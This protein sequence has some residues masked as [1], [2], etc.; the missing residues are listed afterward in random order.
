MGGVK[1]MGGSEK[2]DEVIFSYFPLFWQSFLSLF[3]RLGENG[4]ALF[5]PRLITVWLSAALAFGTSGLALQLGANQ[6]YAA[7]AAGSLLLVPTQIEFGTSCYVQ[8]WLSLLTIMTVSGIIMNTKR[9]LYIAGICAGL[10]ASSKYS[11]LFVPLL[12][13]FIVLLHQPHRLKTFLLMTAL[14]CHTHHQQ[15]SKYLQ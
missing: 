9:G 8:V 6:K 14:C 1:K 11:G 5:N 13:T 2:T 4:F 10:A 3:H 12:G 15:Q 7:L